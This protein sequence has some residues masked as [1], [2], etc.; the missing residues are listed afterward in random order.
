[1]YN[2]EILS[3]YTLLICQCRVFVTTWP[4]CCMSMFQ[5]YVTVRLWFPQLNGVVLASDQEVIIMCKPTMS[6][7]IENRAAGFSGAL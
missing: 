2:D 3:K 6:T 1:M 5:G 7:I 4:N